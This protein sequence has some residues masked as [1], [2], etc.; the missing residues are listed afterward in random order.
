MNFMYWPTPVK[1]PLCS[2]QRVTT[3]PTLKRRAAL[4]PQGEA[5]TATAEMA[6]LATPG[7][8][9]IS[10]LCAFIGTEAPQ[11]LKAL[12]VSAENEEGVSPALRTDGT[13]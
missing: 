11:T 6:E 10:E 8:H 12:I 5:P 9:T 13:R 1:T 4:A 7:V 3:P 2:P